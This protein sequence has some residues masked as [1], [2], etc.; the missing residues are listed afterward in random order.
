MR[1]PEVDSSSLEKRVDISTSV[2]LM[3]GFGAVTV[4]DFFL[5]WDYFVLW[6]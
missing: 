3:I 1:R 5:L 4:A 2:S 6:W